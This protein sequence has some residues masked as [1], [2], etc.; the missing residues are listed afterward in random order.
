MNAQ[1]NIVKQVR[2]ELEKKTQERRIVERLE[3]PSFEK[4]YRDGWKKIFEKH[5]KRLMTPA[6]HAAVSESLGDFSLHGVSSIISKHGGTLI[7][8]GGDD[9][10]AILPV[11]TALQAAK[12]IQEYYTSTYKLIKRNS[13]PDQRAV[14]T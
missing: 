3:M 11:E 6:I 13:P 8:A 5:N 1:E 9:V 7:Y 12:G 10:C 4:K 2:G 14:A